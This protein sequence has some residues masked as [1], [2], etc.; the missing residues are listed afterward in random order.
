MRTIVDISV[1]YINKG[2]TDEFP[3][4]RISPILSDGSPAHIQL[5]QHRWKT[6][7]LTVYGEPG[8]FT[9]FEEPTRGTEI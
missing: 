1:D 6:V 9:E 4:L 3:V 5:E 2:R 8:D 7:T